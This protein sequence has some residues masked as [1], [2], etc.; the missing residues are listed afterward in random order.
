M[1]NA[2]WVETLSF[3]CGFSGEFSEEENEIKRWNVQKQKASFSWCVEY[4]VLLLVSERIGFWQRMWWWEQCWWRVGAA[5]RC[6]HQEN[7]SDAGWCV[8][9]SEQHRRP[10]TTC[11]FAFRQPCTSC[12][13]LA[14]SWLTAELEAVVGEHLRA[15]SLNW[16]K[17]PQALVRVPFLL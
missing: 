5:L 8:T 9:G 13:T 6:P 4:W 16:I 1:R 14:A 3:W 12:V 17:A 11:H 2:N 10:R 15:A 7:Y